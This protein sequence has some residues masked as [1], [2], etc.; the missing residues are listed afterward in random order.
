MVS[1]AQM[2]S[3]NAAIATALP[4]KLVAVFAGATSGIGETALKQFAR[5]AVQPRVYFLG[6]TTASGER[7]RAEL[8]AINPGGEY[9]FLSVDVSLLGT[10]DTVCRQIRERETAINLL[11]LT[12]GTL[13]TGKDTAEGLYYPTAVTYYARTRLIVNLLP[14]LRTATGLRRVVT[15]F[16]GTK[17]GPI[18]TDDFATRHVPILAARGHASAIMTL[19]LEAIA[20]TA[21]EVS[22]VH[23]F[24]GPVKTNLGKDVRTPAFIIVGALFK[25]LW[26]FI[27]IP[28]AEA[29]DRQ[30]FFATSARYPPA[31]T[32]GGVVG[33][34]DG[35]PLPEG[36]EVA[37]G[38]AG[39]VGGGVYSTNVDGETLS[40]KVAQVLA[41]MRDEGV[42]GKVWAHTEDEFVRIAGSVAL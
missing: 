8:Q 42:V 23:D 41:R 28:F 3:S 17:E 36:V 18:H 38:S 1:L 5:H 25:L 22:F 12:T 21:P 15:V 9:V 2:R 13:I 14:L 6:R 11:F 4:A 34:A 30:L 20:V 27:G 32:A 10:V 24:P 29:G 16:A 40:P 26:P 33:S 7:V 35:V 37:R 19:S 39:A 31:R